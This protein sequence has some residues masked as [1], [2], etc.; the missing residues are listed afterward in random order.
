[1]LRLF[2]GS[3]PIGGD[4]GVEPLGPGAQGK[5]YTYAM[6]TD[7]ELPPDLYKQLAPEQRMPPVHPS[8]KD[9]P[10]A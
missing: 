6:G 1:V 10:G 7:Q 8:T 2:L 3:T 9:S 5:T 4:I